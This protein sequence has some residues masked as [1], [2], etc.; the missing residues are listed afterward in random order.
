MRSFV[1]FALL[2][3]PALASNMEVSVTSSLT[4]DAE[5]VKNRPV[6]KVIT[7]LKDMLKQMEKEGEEDEE[8]YDKTAC[9]CQTNDKE[10]TKSIADAQTRISDLTTAIEEFTASSARL[11]QEIKTLEG[12][13]ARNQK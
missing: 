10:K 9:W 5:G 2:L 4:F 13:V 7:L 8:V 11:Q 3:A 6:S 12:E 1:L